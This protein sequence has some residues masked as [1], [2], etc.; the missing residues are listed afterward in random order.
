MYLGRPLWSSP[1][2]QLHQWPVAT[3]IVVIVAIVGGIVVVNGTYSSHDFDSYA[4]TIAVA[5]GLLGIGRG[6]ATKP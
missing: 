5:A 3:L 1:M 2:K 4:R 6:L